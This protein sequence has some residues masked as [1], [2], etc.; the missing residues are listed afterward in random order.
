MIT[1]KFIKWNFPCFLNLPYRTVLGKPGTPGKRL[2]ARL[3]KLQKAVWRGLM[4]IYNIIYLLMILPKTLSLIRFLL[5]WSLI[6]PSL[7]PHLSPRNDSCWF[8]KVWMGLDG[9]GWISTNVSVIY[10]FGFGWIRMSSYG[11]GWVWMSSDGF[12]WFLM[13]SDGF[14]WAFVP[15]SFPHFASWP[16]TYVTDTTT[17]SSTSLALCQRSTLRSQHY[18]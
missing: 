1:E 12:R 15:P 16:D 2:T 9:F 6:T 4:L 10:L 17:D 18:Y 14:G 8:R 5:L 11:F 13:G 3:C 7:R